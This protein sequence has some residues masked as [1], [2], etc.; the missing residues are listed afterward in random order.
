MMLAAP[1][2]RP[3]VA[4]FVNM[5]VFECRRAASS[6]FRSLRRTTGGTPQSRALMRPP[7]DPLG[8]PPHLRTGPL[9]AAW[10]AFLYPCCLRQLSHFGILGWL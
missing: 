4:L 5:V 3:L 7:Y 1:G 6:A 8:T 10:P 9:C 2:L